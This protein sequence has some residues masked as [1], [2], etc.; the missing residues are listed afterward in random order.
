MLAGVKPLA[1]PMIR[2]LVVLAS[3]ALVDPA[4]AEACSCMMPTFEAQRDQAA[5]IFE[6]RADEVR[7]DGDELVV[8][9]HVTQSWRGVTT[10]QVEIRTASNA[11]AC[12]YAFEVGT[13][14]L[15]YAGRRDE[16]PLAVSLCS[17]TARADDA[18]EDRQRLGSGTI[19]VEVAD[20]E[21]EPEARRAPP[22][23]RAGCASCAAMPARAPSMLL[24]LTALVA[25][26]LRGR[27]RARS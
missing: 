5:A 11:A 13:H 10:E 2:A 22:A 27:S 4:P 24:A 21:A 16:G 3:L 8:V 14:Y 12:G 18:S 1:S 6:G 20:D 15:V 25:L 23:T 17:R 7:S 9:F 26:A 19:P